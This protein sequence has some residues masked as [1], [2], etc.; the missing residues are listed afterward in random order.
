MDPAHHGPLT[1]TSARLSAALAGRYRLEREFGAGGMATVWLAYDLKHDR[2]VAVKVLHPHLAA[3]VGAERFL[4]EIKTTAHLQHPHILPLFDSGEADGLLFYVMPFVDGESLRHRITREKRLPI[5]DAVRITSEVASALDYAHRQGVI[6]RDIKPENILLQ[7]G[8]ALVADFGIAL[9]PSAG[10]SRLTET[11]MSMGTPPYMSPEQA[12]GERQLDARSDIYA[13]GAM[14]YEMLTGAPPFTGPSAQA[15]VAKVI[16]EKPVPPSRLRREIPVPVEDAV[17]TALQKDPAN[18]FASAGA[19]QAAL[20]ERG[21]TDFRRMRLRQLEAVAAVLLAIAAIGGYLAIHRT[22]G[23]GG[24]PRRVAMFP[25]SNKSGD[26]ANS[27][28]S[29]G[30]RDEITA[31]MRQVPGLTVIDASAKRFAEPDVDVHAAGRELGVDAILTGTL[32]RADTTVRL[33]VELQDVPTLAVLFDH[34]YDSKQSDLYKLEDSLAR[35][36]AS[37]LRLTLTP[38][39]L[40]VSR[41]GRTTNPAAHDLYLRGLF[42]FGKRTCPDIRK[43]IDYFVQATEADSL[44]ASAYSGLSDAYSVLSIFGCIRPTDGLPQAEK[45]ARRAIQLDSTLAQ[46]HTSLGIVHTHDWDLPAAQAQ[47]TRAV[48]IDSQYS[49]AHLFL[50]WYFVNRGDTA[51]AIVQFQRA[52]ELDP[53]SVILTTRVGSGFYYARRYKEAIGWFRKAL[54][55][56]STAVMPH[57]ELAR[58]WL[59]LGGCDSALAEA[60]FIKG[61]WPNNEGAIAGYASGRCHHRGEA[62]GMLSEL[63]KQR[64]KGEFVL[65]TKIALLYLGLDEKNSAFAWLDSARVHHESGALFLK[66]DPWYDN[67]RGD[68]RFARLVSQVGKQSGN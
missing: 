12:L 9:A 56:D 8:R 25:F 5:G 21:P 33:S 44:Y 60:S 62:E 20:E 45:A 64:A 42:F 14:L 50:G 27:S 53:L 22:G 17:L 65:A 37:D 29:D 13:V 39:Q 26:S 10:G 31:A 18:R 61:S 11:G 41:A 2:Q 16:T 23:A 34:A 38:A 58:A 19:L 63:L 3:V 52:R 54:E 57:A 36:I 35:S 32:R 55:L 30:L 51:Q 67:L 40:A 43:G 15:I 47:L 28:F 59:Q 68:P 24:A 49:P 48:T 7:D 4:K 46:A 1:D 6:H 66:T